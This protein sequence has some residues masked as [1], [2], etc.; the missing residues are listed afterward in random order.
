[1]DECGSDQNAGAEVLGV[2]DD[3]VGA[4][5]AGVAGYQRKAASCEDRTVSERQP[6]VGFSG[7]R[8]S[9]GCV[10]IVLSA[11]IRIKAATCMN[12]S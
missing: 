4:P 9:V 10:H 2:E 3:A 5:A 8:S 12:V 1:M 6:E 7:N 11:R